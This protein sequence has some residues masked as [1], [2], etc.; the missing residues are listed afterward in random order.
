MK[1][2]G[3]KNS[4]HPEFDIYLIF[5]L[6]F[7]FGNDTTSQN[8]FLKRVNFDLSY[9]SQISEVCCN[10]KG[11]ISSVFSCFSLFTRYVYKYIHSFFPRLLLD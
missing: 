2:F 9:R 4:W 10:I 11:V 1:D 6:L 8:Y 5:I 3:M 7:I